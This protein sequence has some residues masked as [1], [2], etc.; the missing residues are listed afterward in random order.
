M[1]MHYQEHAENDGPIGFSEFIH[2]HYTTDHPHQDND[3]DTEPLP[4]QDHHSV[5]TVVATPKDFN[6]HNIKIEANNPQTI[7]I[8]NYNDDFYSS[9]FVDQIWQPPRTC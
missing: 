5:F 4:F 3:G 7:N 1:F 8:S 9:S 2:I 6:I